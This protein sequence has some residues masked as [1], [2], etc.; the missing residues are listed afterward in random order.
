MKPVIKKK[1]HLSV[2]KVAALSQPREKKVCL[3]SLEQTTCP[4]CDR[5]DLC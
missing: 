5:T 3:T 2:I 4:R 1:L